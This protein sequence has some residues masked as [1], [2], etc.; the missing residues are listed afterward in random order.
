MKQ[1]HGTCPKCFHSV[2]V[3]SGRSY[4]SCPHCGQPIAPPTNLSGYRV[5]DMPSRVLPA[6]PG[7]PALPRQERKPDFIHRLRMQSGLLEAVGL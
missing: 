2:A 1:V 5:S 3:L 4:T 7:R 6:R